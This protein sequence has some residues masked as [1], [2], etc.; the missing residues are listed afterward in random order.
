MLVT[1]LVRG[2][3]NQLTADKKTSLWSCGGGSKTKTDPRKPL[4]DLL[5]EDVL[6]EIEG[7]LR[8]EEQGRACAYLQTKADRRGGENPD[9]GGVGV[10]LGGTPTTP[11][12][13]RGFGS[14]NPDDPEPRPGS[15]RSPTRETPELCF[16]FPFDLL[17]IF[18]HR[19]L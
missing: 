17:R 18:R 12:P 10:L 2:A 1:G 4:S 5:D 14:A 7:D 3:A 8:L 6:A 16:C 9:P 19:Y 13:G 11:D 15:A